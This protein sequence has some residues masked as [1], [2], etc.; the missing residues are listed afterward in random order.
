M[1]VASMEHRL[2]KASVQATQNTAT[3]MTLTPLQHCRQYDI[4]KYKGLW[5]GCLYL[6]GPKTNLGLYTSWDGAATAVDRA[7]IFLV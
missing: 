1:Q 5:S 6:R 2:Y 4:R 7:L 3:S